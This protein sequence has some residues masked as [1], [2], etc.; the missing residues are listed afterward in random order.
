MLPGA[1][2]VDVTMLVTY[3]LLQMYSSQQLHN[4]M[5]QYVPPIACFD[6]GNKT[7]HCVEIK[8]KCY[9]P[10]PTCKDVCARNDTEERK[11]CIEENDVVYY[12][13]PMME[14]KLGCT[15]IAFP[16]YVSPAEDQYYGALVGNMFV[17]AL[18]DR[19]GRR[20]VLLCCL[21]A[22]VPI[23]VLSGLLKGWYYFYICRF[24]L[25]VTIAGTMAVGF[26]F[27]AELIS[28]KHRFKLRTFCSWTNG[29]LLMVLLA[30]IAGSFRPAAFAHAAAG[31]I[32]LFL[33]LALPEP[34]IWLKRR[35]KFEK[36]KEAEAY[37]N[38]I[39]GVEVREEGGADEASTQKQDRVSYIQAL[40][41]KELRINVFVLVVMW[42]TAGLSTYSVDLNGADM[43]TNMWLGQYLNSGIASICRVIVGFADLKFKWLGRRLVYIISMSIAIL[44]AIALILLL[45]F[46]GRDIKKNVIY[47][48]AYL[49]AYNSLAVHWEPCYMGAAELIP[50]EVRA[51]NTAILNIVTR[52][53]NILAGRGVALLKGGDHEYMISVIVLI[54]NLIS[55]VTTVALLKETKGI[56]LDKVGRS[57]QKPKTPSVKEQSIQGSKESKP[58]LST[59]SKTKEG[60]SKSKEGLEGMGSKVDEA[61]GDVSKPASKEGAEELPKRESAEKPPVDEG[62][63]EPEKESADKPAGDEESKEPAKEDRPPEAEGRKEPAKK[64]EEEK[65]DENKDSE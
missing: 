39:K 27:C 9:V 37:L 24:L 34:P 60:E 59:E 13:S 32:P 61:K 35:E 28:T 4:V 53:G 46:F 20:L 65:G 14:Y 42:F 21:C 64:G 54:S 51:T 41:D 62:S 48:I 55:F 38:R 49:I 25:G 15:D 31:L 22:G 63:K 3:Q 8:R 36:M 45:L 29:R 40:R 30:H 12:W 19:F 50:T 18:A 10:C 5:L 6:A 44:A 52:V 47:L 17:G 11:K 1:W 23:M 43:T 57:P 58:L 16:Q 26:C 33:I 7:K 2:R 56:S